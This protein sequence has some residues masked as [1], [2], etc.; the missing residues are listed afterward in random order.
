VEKV[1]R[2]ILNRETGGD[3]TAVDATGT[4]YGGYQFQLQTSDTAAM[5]MKRPDL[6]GIPAN[7]WRSPDQDAA[8]Y[9]IYNC[10]KGRH[11]WFGGR[12]PCS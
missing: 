3:Y 11:H 7:Q 12:F 8:F 5:R 4:W 1:R 6:V 9:L 10:G 2:C